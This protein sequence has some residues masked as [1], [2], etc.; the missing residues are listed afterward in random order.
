[1]TGDDISAAASARLLGLRPAEFVSRRRSEA[2]AAM[3]EAQAHRVRGETSEAIQ[4]AYQSDFTALEAY[5]VDS[6]VAVGDDDL[7]T[8]TIRWDL[9]VQSV[10][11]V[12]GLP[13]DFSRAV[14]VIRS[15]IVAGIGEADGRR[16]IESLVPA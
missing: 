13:D 2:A 16:L 3:L 7:L 6:A 10:S 8:V 12:P 15:A 4:S 9:A 1:M 11:E 14:G 5:L